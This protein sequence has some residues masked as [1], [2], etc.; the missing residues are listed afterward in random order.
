MMPFGQAGGLPQTMAQFGSGTG[1]QPFKTVQDYD[2]WLGRVHGFTAWADSAIGNFR[3]GLKAGVVLPQ[4]LVVKMIPQL[5][6]MA[7]ADPTKSLFYGPIAKLPASLAG[8]RQS[9]S[10]RRLPARH[11]H[12]AGARLSKAERVSK[13]R[14]LAQCPHHLG[15]WRLARRRGG[16]PLRSESGHHHRQNA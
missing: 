16:L 12:R 13:K 7:V 11:S 3:Q 6:A 1:A 10:D 4:A 14:V 2:N 8:R 5:D 15:L 9:A